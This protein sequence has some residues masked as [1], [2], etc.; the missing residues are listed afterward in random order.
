MEGAM[1]PQPLMNH[2]IIQLAYVVNDLE[3]ARI[4]G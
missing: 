4:N 2:K 3:G 1:F